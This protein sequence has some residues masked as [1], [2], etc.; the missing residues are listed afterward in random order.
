M[1]VHDASSLAHHLQERD[2]NDILRLPGPIL[3]DSPRG[4]AEGLLRNFNVIKTDHE[5][6]SLLNDIGIFEND[7]LGVIDEKLIVSSGKNCV[8]PNDREVH[9]T[10]TGLFFGNRNKALSEESI[11]TQFI[12]ELSSLLSK[13]VLMLKLE[14]DVEIMQIPDLKTE[15]DESQ[16]RKSREHLKKLRIMTDSLDERNYRFKTRVVQKL[17]KQT[18]FSNEETIVGYGGGWHNRNNS[19][20]NFF[21]DMI[22]DISTNVNE[23]IKSKQSK[24]D[25]QIALLTNDLQ[26][27]ETKPCCW[28]N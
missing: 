6:Y 9:P 19:I 12:L 23:M 21:K 16:I 14:L 13:V 7:L 5:E 20:S 22:S 3:S 17:S 24:I 4:R 10:Y 26:V 28:I 1:Y 18:C 25:N 11:A 8:F 15:Q 2:S 27:A